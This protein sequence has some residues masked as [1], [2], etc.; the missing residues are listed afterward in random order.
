MK[1]ENEILKT[2]IDFKRNS[3]IY[4]LIKDNEIVYVGQTKAGLSRI[5][6]HN[7][8]KFDSYSIIECEQSE[9][10]ELENEYIIK[11]NPKYNKTINLTDRFIS[12]ANATR[13]TNGVILNRMKKKRNLTVLSN[14][15]NK[16]FYDRKEFFN[17]ID[18]MAFEIE[19]VLKNDR[20]VIKR[21]YMTRQQTINHIFSIVQSLNEMQLIERHN[22]EVH[23]WL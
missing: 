8:K 20:W 18:V 11:F 19:I 4:F 5:F 22:I 16:E 21:W 10:D 2:K 7:D 14:N 3:F 12:K 23:K 1:S 17:I 9:L 6:Q 15:C 13:K